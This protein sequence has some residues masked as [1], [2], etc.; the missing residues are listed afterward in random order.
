MDNVVHLWNPRSARHL[1]RHWVSYLQPIAML[2]SHSD[3]RADL[4]I[5]PFSRD[6]LRVRLHALG[7]MSEKSLRPG[8][9]IE[10][11]MRNSVIFIDVKAVGS[12]RLLVEFAS[13]AEDEVRVIHDPVDSSLLLTA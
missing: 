12:T 8:E 4:Q 2:G 3:D 11:H 1:R 9:E 10:I 7:V 13:N 6:E 5:A